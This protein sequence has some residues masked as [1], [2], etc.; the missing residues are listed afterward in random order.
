MERV[1]RTGIQK[2]ITKL[3]VKPRGQGKKNG[4]YHFHGI[5]GFSGSFT[6]ILFGSLKTENNLLSLKQSLDDGGNDRT[7]E[8]NLFHEKITAPHVYLTFD[9]I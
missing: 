4:N 9:L 3:K 6:G 8:N 7:S 5:M 1:K 2:R